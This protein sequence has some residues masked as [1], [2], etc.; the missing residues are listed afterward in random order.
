M[1]FQTYNIKLQGEFVVAFAGLLRKSPRLLNPSHHLPYDLYKLH[2]FSAIKKVPAVAGI[3]DKMHLG[4]SSL[5]VLQHARFGKSM[6]VQLLPA[7]CL[8]W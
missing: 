6:F 4:Y 5:R 2:S 7:E 1:R 8:R 3:Y